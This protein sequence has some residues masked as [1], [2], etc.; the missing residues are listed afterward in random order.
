MRRE[1]IV[2]R[3]KLFRSDGLLLVIAVGALAAIMLIIGYL[4]RTLHMVTWPIQAVVF[5]GLLVLIYFLITRQ[6]TSFIYALEDDTFCVI[7]C[8]G[9][10]QRMTERVERKEILFIA[11]YREARD[12]G[13][14]GRE[15][16]LC[17]RSKRE[18]VV[19]A[20]RRN[21]KVEWLIISP[22]QEMLSALEGAVDE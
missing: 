2:E 9:R 11:P 8:V 13:E 10:K 6:F 18:G 15:Y 5:L 4:E 7:R 17:A 20:H 1:Q 21:G 3:K 16:A 19:V 12:R 14:K 22:D